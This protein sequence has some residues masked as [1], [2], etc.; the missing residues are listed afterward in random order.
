MLFGKYINKFYFKYSIFFIL[1]ILALLF[2]NYYQ[3][4]IP[5]ICREILNGLTDGSL[6]QN[7]DLIF[8]FLRDL[9]VIA[10]IM[11]T[12]RIAWR[13]FIFGASIRIESD[14]RELLFEHAESL[15][16]QFYK[17]HKTGSIMAL[18]S[19]DIPFIKQGFGLGTILFIDAVFLGLLALY[20]MFITNWMLTLFS[21]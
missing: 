10:L 3:L 13:V 6:A 5:E 15:S 16:Y 21:L 9:A 11:F 18:F 19:N 14:V 2:V 7:G 12:G 17:E 8:R 4:K 20:K 1:G